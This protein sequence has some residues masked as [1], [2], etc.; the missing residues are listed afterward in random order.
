M[1]EAAGSEDHSV[2]R[3]RLT[4]AVGAVVP[5]TLVSP[6][7]VAVDAGCRCVAALP[8][9]WE[10][11]WPS[12]TPATRRLRPASDTDTHLGRRY[13]PGQ[14]PPVHRPRHRS[15]SAPATARRTLGV[16]AL[17]WATPADR[18]G[19]AR[20]PRSPKDRT[21]PPHGTQSGFFLP[22]VQLDA[23][24]D[25]LRSPSTRVI[26]NAP[27]DALEAAGPRIDDPSPQEAPVSST[28]TG[29][30]LVSRVRVKGRPATDYRVPLA[31]TPRRSG[32]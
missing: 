21:A 5:T 18:G 6:E 17:G 20:E 11:P 23:T 29:P 16:M 12:A 22:R 31:S 27:R 1:V 3:P 19:G 7:A 28:S 8:A 30:V 13:R 26:R 14:S 10:P 2:Q 4:L 24:A 25:R 9:R 32:P 15:L